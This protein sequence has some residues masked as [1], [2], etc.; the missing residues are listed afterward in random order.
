MGGLGSKDLARYIKTGEQLQ[1]SI[2]IR[3]KCAEC[4]ANYADGRYDC[5]ICKC[6]LYPFMPY[7]GK[8][9]KIE[10]NLVGGECSAQPP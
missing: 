9:A 3:A 6:P 4:T 1:R 10:L 7:H 5:E 8:T 2:A